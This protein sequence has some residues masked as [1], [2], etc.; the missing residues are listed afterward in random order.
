MSKLKFKDP[1]PTN[2]VRT[3][4]GVKALEDLSEEELE[5]YLLLLNDIIR[6]RYNKLKINKS[7]PLNRINKV[8]RKNKFHKK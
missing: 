7:L 2:F 1:L 8:E 4:R 3:N 6:D 5:D